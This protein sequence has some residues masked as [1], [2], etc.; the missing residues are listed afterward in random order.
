MNTIKILLIDD[1]PKS[2]MK[3]EGTDKFFPTL[4]DG[5]TNSE[6]DVNTINDNFELGWLQSPRDVVEFRTLSEL[7]IHR[8][9][10]QVL[11]EKGFVPEIILFDYRLSEQLNKYIDIDH[12]EYKNI[13]P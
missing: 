8:K 6:F 12:E 3:D 2:L 7:L 5:Y 11:I 4:H 13:I 10:S 9:G 1:N